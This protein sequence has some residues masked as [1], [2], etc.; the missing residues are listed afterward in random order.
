MK[1]II[2]LFLFSLSLMSGCGKTNVVHNVDTSLSKD[3][4]VTEDNQ[5]EAN[6]RAISNDS[7]A[8]IIEED[9]KMNDE[10]DLSSEPKKSNENDK[11]QID[12]KSDSISDS[13]E[14]NLEHTEM[15]AETDEIK[16]ASSPI[17]K[18]INSNITRIIITNGS[19]G[20]QKEITDASD[21]ESILN[22]IKTLSPSSQD[23]DNVQGYLFSLNLYSGEDFKQSIF[24][25]DGSIG[26][27]NIRYNVESTQDII[28]SIQ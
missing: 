4:K 25:N 11:Q 26:V 27:D 3:T 17:S 7:S 22:Q 21:V 9:E 1:K 18:K 10:N 6:E 5:N 19:T 20:E 24:I 16:N 14:K 23:K 12:S 13:S 15:S 8:T 28:D 2:I